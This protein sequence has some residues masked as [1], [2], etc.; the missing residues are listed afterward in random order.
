MTKVEVTSRVMDKIE[1][2]NYLRK[3]QGFS[4]RLSTKIVD[5]ALLKKSKPTFGI[6][7][8]EALQKCAKKKEKKIK[9]PKFVIKE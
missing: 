3:N 8:E 2:I 5:I 7:F 9:K 4:K 6:A 1:A